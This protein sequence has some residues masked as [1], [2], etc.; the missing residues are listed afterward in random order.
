MAIIIIASSESA[1]VKRQRRRTP[2][3]KRGTSVQE[4][5]NAETRL[6]ATAFNERRS[7]LQLRLLFASILHSNVLPVIHHVQHRS[8]RPQVKV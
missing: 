1:V 4:R 2:L 7:Q 5:A 3:I 8:Q 6:A